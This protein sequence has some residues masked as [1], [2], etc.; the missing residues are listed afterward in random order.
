MKVLISGYRQ[1]VWKEKK[2]EVFSYYRERAHNKIVKEEPVSCHF[3][4][5]EFIFG[6]ED[7]HLLKYRKGYFIF[8]PSDKR[9]YFIFYIKCP[10]CRKR[11]EI[12]SERSWNHHY[13]RRW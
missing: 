6:E 13:E 10:I 1:K 9:G 11:I 7:L 4:G 12:E 5:S 2:Q 8:L 3:C